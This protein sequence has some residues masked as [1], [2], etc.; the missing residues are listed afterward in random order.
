MSAGYTFQSL[1]QGERELAKDHAD[2]TGGT[3]IAEQGL[4][5]LERAWDAHWALRLLCVI[6]FF[7]MSMML[8]VQRG[9]RQWSAGDSALLSNVG[10]I[11]V[12]IVVFSLMVAIVMPA[13]LLVLRPFMGWLSDKLTTQNCERY[14]QSL[15]MAPASKFRDLALRGKDDFL[16]RIYENHEQKREAASQSREKTGQLTAVALLAALADWLVAQWVPGSIGLIGAMVGALGDWAP[17]VIVVVLLCA[18]AI[19][20]WAWFAPWTPNVIYYPPLDEELRDKEKKNK[21]LY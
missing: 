11:A 1:E 3:S 2:Q 6:L 17:A 10:W 21:G 4:G 5:A 16:F 18:G 14:Q 9:L 15:G 20:K 8:H 12:T 7:D 13:I 19:L